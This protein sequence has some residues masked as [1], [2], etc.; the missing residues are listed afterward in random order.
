M[1]RM[2]LT[3]WNTGSISA[4]RI[5][6]TSGKLVIVVTV[7]LVVLFLAGCASAEESA[8]PLAAADAPEAATAPEIIPSSTSTNEPSAMAVPTKTPS[9]TATTAATS[10]QTPAPLRTARDTRTP[11]ASPTVTLTPLPTVPPGEREA[12]IRGL[13][14]SNA[15]CAFRCWWGAVPGQTKWS[16][17]ARFLATFAEEI[18]WNTNQYAANFLRQPAPEVG[19]D[20]RPFYDVSGYYHVSDDIITSVYS[21]D[22]FT[23]HYDIAEVLV[24]H[25]VPDEIGVF[26]TGA[27]YEQPR[28]ELEIWYDDGFRYFYRLYNVTRAGEYATACENG[29]Q[30]HQVWLLEPSS[31]WIGLEEGDL[32]IEEILDM[33]PAAFHAQFSG[34]TEPVCLTLPIKSWWDWEYWP[35]GE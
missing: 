4:A 16:E 5:C 15:D 21:N 17:H 19:G 27:F 18:S 33:T 22:P 35:E 8:A 11:T 34:T 7:A 13:I 26:P 29:L 31:P 12:L 28:L 10:S 1:S 24:R 30:D 2:N 32:R 6:R 14:E 20:S 3:L 9:A 23:S 25:G